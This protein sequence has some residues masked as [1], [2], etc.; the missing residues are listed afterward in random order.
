MAIRGK[1]ALTRPDTPPPT[2]G[3]FPSPLQRS[4]T[5][6]KPSGSRPNPLRSLPA[7]LGCRRFRIRS[8]NPEESGVE[9]D[10]PTVPRSQHYPVVPLAR[11][12]RGAAKRAS[13]WEAEDFHITRVRPSGPAYEEFPEVAAL[14]VR[15]NPVTKL[16][17]PEPVLAI[18]T[19]MYGVPRI[20]HVRTLPNTAPVRQAQANSLVP[21][22][23]GYLTPWAPFFDSH[24]I[25]PHLN[26]LDAV[27]NNGWHPPIEPKLA[28]RSVDPRDGRMHV[29]KVRAIHQPPCGAPRASGRGE[30]N[31]QCNHGR[32]RRFHMVLP[33]LFYT[34]YVPTLFPSRPTRYPLGETRWTSR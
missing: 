26:I 11:G 27:L 14:D 32:R 17:D 21:P 28:S 22:W 9:T 12:K 31:G 15:L 4:G 30:P 13:L 1:E 7:N 19:V 18:A 34:V 29:F 24:T 8:R 2:T 3:E 5:E 6:E 33:A 16:P 20:F 25:S 23:C 10:D